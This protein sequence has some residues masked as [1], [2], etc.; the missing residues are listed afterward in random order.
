MPTPIHPNVHFHGPVPL[1]QL[2][3]TLDSRENSGEALRTHLQRRAE[4]GLNI[5]LYAPSPREL[6]S[7][8]TGEANQLVFDQAFGLLGARATIGGVALTRTGNG[9]TASSHT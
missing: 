5:D 4:T 3:E 7:Y 9:V 8:L 1:E 6:N 2:I